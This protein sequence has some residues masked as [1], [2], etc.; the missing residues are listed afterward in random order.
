[1][2]ADVR[3][4]LMMACI[5]AGCRYYDFKDDMLSI[6]FMNAVGSTPTLSYHKSKTVATINLFPANE[7]PT[8]ICKYPAAAFG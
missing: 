5:H 8:C 4:I 7:A 6:D 2:Y 3:S 1:M